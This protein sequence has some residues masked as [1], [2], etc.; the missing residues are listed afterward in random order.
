M[1]VYTCYG[2]IPSGCGCCANEDHDFIVVA[3][4]E[5]EA[6][7]VAIEFAPGVD[8]DDWDIDVVDRSKF[9]VCDN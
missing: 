4:S 8:A 6:L 3:N 9:G 7:G 5:A 2:S 1:E